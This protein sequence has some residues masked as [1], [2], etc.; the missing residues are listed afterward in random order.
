MIIYNMKT[1]RHVHCWSAGDA[2]IDLVASFH[3][4]E[5]SQTSETPCSRPGDSTPRSQRV[6]AEDL[7]RTVCC[8]ASAAPQDREERRVLRAW[9]RMAQA[10]PPTVST[11]RE[12]RVFSRAWLLRSAF[13]VGIAPNKLEHVF[14]SRRRGA[15]LSI[16]LDNIDMAGLVAAQC[17]ERRD[18]A[19]GPGSKSTSTIIDPASS[20]GPYPCASRR[21]TLHEGGAMLAGRQRHMPGSS[22]FSK[23]AVAF[24]DMAEQERSAPSQQRRRCGVP[25]CLVLKSAWDPRRRRFFP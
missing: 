5:P 6:A 22:C 3:R 23:G 2:F 16:V 11:L 7:S 1:P 25:A 17:A 8:Q 12:C 9:S 4:S 21:R 19:A 10:G 20:P 14:D 18:R 13:A 24:E 15:E